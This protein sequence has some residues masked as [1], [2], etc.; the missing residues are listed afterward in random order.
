[1]YLRIFKQLF[2]FGTAPIL[3]TEEKT[4]GML[5]RLTRKRNTEVSRCRS[6]KNGCLKGILYQS[7]TKKP[8]NIAENHKLLKMGLRTIV[9]TST[10]A[11]I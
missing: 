4:E 6:F 2:M 8:T 10:I 7:C 1:M 9:L 11:N 5:Q 3:P